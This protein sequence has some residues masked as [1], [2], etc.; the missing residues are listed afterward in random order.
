MSN[1]RKLTLTDNEISNC[2]IG[3]KGGVVQASN[4][5][6]YVIG[7]VFKNNA[8]IA[9]GAIYVSSCFYSEISGATFTD[10][11]AAQGGAIYAD[12]GSILKIFGDTVFR[13]NGA[14][15]DGGAI[16]MTNLAVLET[17]DVIVEYNWSIY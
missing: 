6:L 4:T 8:A 3:F 13:G 17:E 1:A 10:N 7:G 5:Y 14:I 2:Y 12:T 16:K 9:G 15:Y 11:Y